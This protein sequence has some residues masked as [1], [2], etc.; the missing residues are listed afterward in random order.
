L[1]ALPLAFLIVPSLLRRRTL[2]ISY[3]VAVGG[4]LLAERAYHYLV[5]LQPDY[6]DGGPFGG[7]G[8]TFRAVWLG[9]F[10]VGLTAGAILR[11]ARRGSR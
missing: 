3:T 8:D 6:V 1:V 5:A 10:L 9:S 11:E 2:F 7:I 4:L